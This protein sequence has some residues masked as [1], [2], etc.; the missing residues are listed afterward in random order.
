MQ[1]SMHLS[2]GTASI[3]SFVD[4]LSVLLNPSVRG[5]NS[6]FPPLNFMPLSPLANFL[7]CLP[8]SV[9]SWRSTFGSIILGIP[10][11][12]P[13]VT[14]YEIPSVSIIRLF[15][16]L[17]YCPTIFTFGSIRRLSLLTLVNVLDVP[18][19]FISS[20]CRLN[21]PRPRLAAI[22]GSAACFKK[23]S[24]TLCP[25]RQKYSNAF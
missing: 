11:L 7:S 5:Q 9:L 13:F 10:S 16:E 19:S 4:V 24:S 3:L 18:L 22:F 12:C 6:L 20:C 2:S 14:Q 15:C 21:S 1:P 17:S 23:L 8:C 25:A